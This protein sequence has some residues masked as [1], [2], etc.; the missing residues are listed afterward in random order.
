MRWFFRRIHIEVKWKVSWKHY[1]HMYDIYKCR[2]AWCTDSPV[3]F[4]SSENV[5]TG[6][7]PLHHHGSMA[8]HSSLNVS[9]VI[10][11]FFVH[12]SSMNPSVMILSQKAL[13]SLRSSTYI[14]TFEI[15]VGSPGMR[16]SALMHHI[17]SIKTPANHN[18]TLSKF[19]KYGFNFKFGMDSKR[20]VQ[21]SCFLKCFN[22]K[23]LV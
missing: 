17:H 22:A 1:F 4:S 7:F 15:K 19:K 6:D 23:M 2:W 8:S 14:W 21:V 16:F 11:K 12:N 20:C 13:I 5:R 3:Q 18:C 9:Q 10:L